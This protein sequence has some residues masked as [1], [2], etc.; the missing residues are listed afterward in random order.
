MAGRRTIAVV[1]PFSSG[2]VFASQ[3]I[4]A[5]ID[6]I[7]VLSRLFP[8]QQL[9]FVPAGLNLSFVCTHICDGHNI[10]DITDALQ[11]DGVS[12]V[13]PGSE[14][15]VNLADTL[16]E[17]LKVPSN[18]T[19]LS[20]CRRDKVCMQQRLTECG[21]QQTRRLRVNAATSDLDLLTFLESVS[22]PPQS[23]ES[24]D[25]QLVVKPT[26]SCGTDNV[27]FAQTSG[28]VRCAIDAILG[29]SNQLGM[30]NSDA[31]IEEFVDGTEF[32]VDTVSSNGVHK[33]MFF[34][35]AAWHFYL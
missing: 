21:L 3:C 26:C 7:R 13:F 27:A 35:L 23:T 32:I 28:Q 6:V 34:Y 2:A 9:K 33:V 30:L 5:G 19:A 29:H 18:G 25:F 1:D 10:D 12:F 14:P 16:S 22:I 11:R 4:D 31:M 8:E 24:P 15:G 20:P 17:R